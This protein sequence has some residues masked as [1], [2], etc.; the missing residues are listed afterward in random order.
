MMTEEGAGDQLLSQLRR[1][2]QHLYDPFELRR[3]PL[4][5]LLP[6]DPSADRVLALR[7]LLHD[8]IQAMRPGED[9]PPGSNAWRIYD[10]LSYRFIEQSSQKEVA[11]DM[12]LSVRQLQRLESTALEEL[13]ER[14]ASQYGL[15]VSPEKPVQTAG[16]QGLLDTIPDLNMVS[17]TGEI[18][19]TGMDFEQEVAWLKKSSLSEEIALAELVDATLSTLAPLIQAVQ[20]QIEISIPPALPSVIGQATVLRQ[21][22]INLFT[23]AL[24][25]AETGRICLTAAADRGKI[26]IH[27]SADCIR[28]AATEEIG[29]ILSIAAQ[30]SGISHGTLDVDLPSAERNE[31][32]ASLTLPSARQLSVLVI[33]DNQDTL[34]LLER[35]LT[36]SRYQFAA[37]RD[38]AQLST[39]VETHHPDIILLDVMLPGIDGWD[40]LGQLKRDPTTH[41][42]PV[43]ISTIL[44]QEALAL[45]LGAADFLRKPF[46]QTQ[47]LAALERQEIPL[48]QGSS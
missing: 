13:C 10:V 24:H 37:G 40:L 45:M 36:G 43:I 21:A 31:F 46:T 19:P 23:A 6:L 22:L 41:H 30:L 29:E 12:A 16:E 35:Y 42:I 9:A 27:L 34:L 48:S 8:A 2:L 28:Q 1:A 7:K 11:A 26:Q 14:L 38:P 32:T 20:G 3:N 47:L 4:Q 17:T 5:Y 39:L 33:D 18:T 25:L 44:P 15:Q